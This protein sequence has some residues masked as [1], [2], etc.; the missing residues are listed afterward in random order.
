MIMN[1]KL[2]DKVLV[3]MLIT[4]LVVT[5]VPGALPGGNV[6]ANDYEVSPIEVFNAD[7]EGNVTNGRPEGWKYWSSGAATGLSVSEAVYQSGKQSLKLDVVKQNVAVESTPFAVEAGQLIRAK[8][9]AYVEEFSTTNVNGGV[10]MWIRYYKTNVITES[11][12]ILSD[13]RFKTVAADVVTEQWFDIGG[14]ATVPVEA[15]YAIV[16]LYVHRDNTFL[17][18]YDDIVLEN[19]VE[20]STPPEEPNDG[21]HPLEVVNADF[22]GSIINGR[23]EGWKYWSGGVATGLSVSEDISQSGEQSLKLNVVKQNV[24]VESTPFAVEAGQLIRAKASAYIEEFSTMNVNGGVEMWIRYYK[25]NVIKDSNR[26]LKDAKL[27]TLAADVLTEQWFDMSTET[28]VPAEANYAIVFLYVHRDNTFLG[29]YDDIVVEKY[30]EA[31][32]PTI[33]YNAGFELPATGS[34]IPGWT[35]SPSPLGASTSVALSQE[36]AASGQTSLN[37]S[38]DNDASAVLVYSEYMNVEAGKTYA[39]SA[40][41][42][43]GSGSGRVYIKYYNESNQE[44][45]SFNQGAENPQN[46]WNLIRTEGMAPSNAVK[47]RI[48]LYSGLATQDVEVYYDDVTFEEISVLTMPYEFGAPVSL[49]DA[50]VVAKTNGGAIGNGEIYFGA[51]GSPAQFYVLDALSGDVKFSAPIP[52]TDVVWAVTVGSDGNAYVAGTKT[53]IMYRYNRIEKNLEELGENPSNKWIWDLDASSDGKIY[54]STYPD[55]KAFVYDIATQEYMDYGTLKVGQE[56]VR[57]SGVNDKYF[58]AGIGTT[59]YLIRIDRETGVATEIE[60]PISGIRAGISVIL[61]YG[62]KLYITHGTSLLILNEE[63]DETTYST[64]KRI[65]ADDDD[66]FDGKLSPPSP[67]DDNIMYYRNKHTSELWTYNIEQNETA[68]VL[69]RVVLP[70][71]SLQAINWVEMT[72]GANAGRKVLVM[73]TNEVD[74]VVFDPIAH[75]LEKN[76]PEVAKSGIEINSIKLGPDGKLYM[77]GYQGAM[78]IYDANKGYFEKQEKE[79]HQISSMGFLNNKV[80]FGLYGGA[81]IWRYDLAKPYDLGVNPGFYHDIPEGQSRTFTFA[82]GD[83]KLFVGSVAD[84]QQLGGA[85]TVF[86]EPTESWNTYRNVVQNQSIIG[87]AY[88]EGKVY[89]GTSIWGGLGIDPSETVAKLFEWDVATA[90]KTAEIIPDV[91]GFI[92][93]MIGELSI[94]PDGNLYGAMWGQSDIS[95]SSFA[96]FVMDPITKDILRSKVIATGQKA[97][98]WRPFFLYWGPDGLLYTTLGRQLIVFDPVTLA[99]NKLVNPYVH[100]MAL[101]PDGSVYYKNGAQLMKLPVRMSEAT[102]AAESSTIEVGKTTDLTVSLKLVNGLTGNADGTQISYTVSDPLIATMENDTLVG[103]KAG[104]ITVTATVT[105]DAVVK[106][107][108]PIE[109][110]VAPLPQT[111]MIIVDQTE[112]TNKDVLVT[113]QYTNNDNLKLYR[114]DGADWQ[115]YNGPISV[116]TNGIIE[117]KAVSTLG[118][119]SDIASFEITNIDKAAPTAMVYLSTDII[120]QP[121]H[122]MVAITANVVHEDDQPGVNTVVLS[123]ITSNEADNGL[124]DGD[125]PNDIQNASYG[126]ADFSFDLRGERSGMGDGRVYTV[127]YTITDQAGNVTTA[128]ATVTVPKGSRK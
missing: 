40:R 70:E 72:E 94:G 66:A 78:S 15:N 87:L 75:T 31:E 7:F 5:M 50:T 42:Y 69:P 81:V 93:Q 3:I 48:L 101:G 125:T 107:S 126:A 85:L 29:Y 49:G 105:Q 65:M 14:E 84:Y 20:S 124:G 2:W 63:V 118:T 33:P 9:S 96:L 12:R 92:P 55:S 86:D 102:L 57:G 60:T 110:T 76:Y 16:F 43:I 97:S 79:P 1:R 108:E 104:A 19:L 11:N 115:S 67:H 47:A 4:A 80:Y 45:D 38:D 53:G 41:L 30:I 18:Y 28:T 26:I 59:G 117:A 64:V 120:K 123:S 6:Y 24:A 32:E 58:Y 21:Y 39:A 56:Y 121:N 116:A 90:T 128:S 122:Q 106:T 22:E 89:G 127:T 95:S 88:K 37:I 119:E 25:T 112:L 98:D 46:S 52:S 77:G 100:V 10:E 83:N 73:L 23:P 44:V 27:K 111:P 13:A 34:E 71:K 68:P 109:I 113:I 35:V 103:L 36:Q 82:N 61:S 51:S 99:Y 8:A 114:L 91:P 62:N 17:G 54:G 74:H